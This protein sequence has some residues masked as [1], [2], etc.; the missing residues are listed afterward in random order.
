MGSGAN[1]LYSHLTLFLSLLKYFCFL[2]ERC[3]IPTILLLDQPSQVYFPRTDY[4]EVFNAHEL[5]EK[6]PDDEA[7]LVDEDLQ[8]VQNMYT[9]LVR[10]CEETAKV[11]GVT[12]QII[13]A[14]H[15]DNLT[16]NLDLSFESLVRARWRSSSK[17]LIDLDKINGA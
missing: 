2:K 16:L 14:D 3:R 12:P 11:T 17:G 4:G 1:W 9:Q 5:S 7:S 15:A 8:S 10:F 13:V 6:R